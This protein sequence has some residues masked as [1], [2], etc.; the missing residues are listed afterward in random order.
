MRY[1]IHLNLCVALSVA[2]LLFVTGIEAT[3]IK[4]SITQLT[5][6]GVVRK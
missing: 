4:V 2:I 5:D 1:R 6:V 3:Q